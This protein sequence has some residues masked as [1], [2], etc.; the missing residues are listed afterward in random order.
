MKS[1][2]ALG[3]AFVAVVLVLLVFGVLST[4][5]G[6]AE[7]LS[8]SEAFEGIDVPVI[9]TVGDF[10]DPAQRHVVTVTADGHVTFEGSNVATLQELIDALKRGAERTPGEFVEGTSH[11]Y[12]GFAVIRADRSAPWGVLEWVYGACREAVMRSVSFDVRSEA[13]GA[14]GAF[15][16]EYR[17]VP[18]GDLP[19]LDL[20]A[21][22]PDQDPTVDV[23]PSAEDVA[24]HSLFAAL[25]NVREPLMRIDR[26]VTTAAALRAFDVAVRAGATELSW[27]GLPWPHQ[28]A[29]AQFVAEAVRCRVPTSTTCIHVDGRPVPPAH[30]TMPRIERLRGVAGVP[31]LY[32][33]YDRSDTIPFPLPR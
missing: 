11:R 5:M 1:A 15:T 28:R 4:E 30:S 32:T 14:E 10:P 8:S 13:D 6:S 18:G 7:R 27:A 31:A 2:W 3:A 20:H 12:G 26:R 23:F 17:P 21:L 16:I 19:P 22:H 9:G 33:P 25:Q 24:P 29:G